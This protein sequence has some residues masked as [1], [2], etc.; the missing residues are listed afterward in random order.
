MSFVALLAQSPSPTQTTG[1]GSGGVSSLLFI[2]LIFGGFYFL[3]I[4]P[5]RNRLRQHQE[6]V[7]AIEVGDEVETVAGMFGRVLR[8]DDSLVWV[9][10]IPGT[11]PVKMSRAAIRRRVIPIDPEPSS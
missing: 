1:S 4:R 5:Q 10:L 8:A 2:L 3:M 7:R 6:M 9:E 11:E